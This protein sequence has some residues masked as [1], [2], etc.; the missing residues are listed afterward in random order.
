MSIKSPKK[1]KLIFNLFFN[2]KNWLKLLNKNILLT[3]Y[4][5]K[6]EHISI[7]SR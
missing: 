5:F 6:P 7:Y 3:I 2:K 4:F 1:N